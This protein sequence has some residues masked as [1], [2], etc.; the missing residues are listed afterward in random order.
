MLFKIGFLQSDPRIR[1]RFA[2]E[3][4][5]NKIRFNFTSKLYFTFAS[6]NILIILSVTLGVVRAISTFL[7]YFS[8]TPSL[9]FIKSPQLIYSSVKFSRALYYIIRVDSAESITVFMVV[10]HNMVDHLAYL[11]V[12]L[13]LQ[14]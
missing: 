13:H 12:V 3:F 1:H 11:T 4:T 5:F 9:L 8:F 6:N 10:I 2:L 7:V 14:T